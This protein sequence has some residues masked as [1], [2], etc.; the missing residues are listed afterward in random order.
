MTGKKVQTLAT[1]GPNDE[2]AGLGEHDKRKLYVSFFWRKRG[3]CLH[4]QQ[5]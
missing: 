3:E 4:H 5:Q 1:A 2:A